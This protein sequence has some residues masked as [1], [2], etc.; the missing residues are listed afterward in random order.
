MALDYARSCLEFFESNPSEDWDVAFA[1][2]EMALA[3]YASGDTATHSEH[4]ARAL[5]INPRGY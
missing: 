5:E 3:G 2:L 1:H 4:Y